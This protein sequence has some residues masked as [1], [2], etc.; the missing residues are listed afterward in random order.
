MTLKSGTIF[1]LDK[2]MKHTDEKRISQ[3]TKTI[4]KAVHYCPC[5][6]YVGSADDGA[7][8]CERRLQ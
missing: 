4:S 6:F 7:G 2:E 1:A 3:K 5:A 8:I